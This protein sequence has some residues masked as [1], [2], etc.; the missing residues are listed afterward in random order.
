MFS[1]FYWCYLWAI[2]KALPV[3]QILPYTSWLTKS[4]VT[5]QPPQCPD[6]LWSP[7]QLIFNPVIA[8]TFC[9]SVL[10]F[11]W[12]WNDDSFLK[13]HSQ[14]LDRTLV[15]SW[16]FANSFFFAWR[17]CTESICSGGETPYSCLN[18]LI[19]KGWAKKNCGKACRL[20]LTGWQF[21]KYNLL[22]L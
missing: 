21:W 16:V 6:L 10:L 5:L 1:W 12:I 20:N 7:E 11:K 19:G 17:R 2:Y 8:W 14:N 22:L 18:E 3:H 9:M 4:L 13:N 15:P